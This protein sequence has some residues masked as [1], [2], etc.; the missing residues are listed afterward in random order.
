MPVKLTTMFIFFAVALALL[1]GHARA[2]VTGPIPNMPTARSGL[3]VAVSGA[4]IYAMGGE[5]VSGFSAAVEEY[6]PATNAWTPRANMPTARYSYGITASNG[7]IY[8]MGGVDGHGSPS[9]TVDEYDPSTNTWMPR[10][11]MPVSLGEGAR[12]A[13]ATN[14]KIYIVGS[15]HGDSSLLEYDPLGD[16]WV[17]RAS[18]P[19]PRFNPGVVANSNGRLYVIGGFAAG[20]EVSTVFEYDPVSNMWGTKASMPTA[21]YA[22][23]TTMVDGKIYAIGG[24]RGGNNPP[25]DLAVVEAYDPV[26]DVWETRQS[27]PTPRNVLGATSTTNGTIFAIGGR[28]DST[29]LAT[30]EAYDPLRDTW[31]TGAATPTPTLTPSLTPTSTSTLAPTA[32]PTLTPTATPTAT[33]TPTPTVCAVRPRVDVQTAVIGLGH[34]QTTITATTSS[35]TPSNFLQ[36]IRFVR[37]DNASINTRDRSN[38]TAPFVEELPDRPR[39]AGFVVSRLVPGPFTVQVVVEDDCGAWPTLVGAGAAAF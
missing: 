1:P 6:D 12:A 8:A 33:I 15:N 7:R 2:T 28:I 5:N 37:L 4:K 3:G 25:F 31:L 16:A 21:R 32:T 38:Q 9:V 30:A 18:M 22:L 10:S 27:M 23:G 29:H 26:T 19:E 39:Q 13:T 20:I 11:P 35:G 36:R 24:E 17:L 14:N 34:L